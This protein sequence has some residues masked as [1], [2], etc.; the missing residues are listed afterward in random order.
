MENKVIYYMN[1]ILDIKEG[2]DAYPVT[3]EIDP[4]NVCNLNCS[5]CMYAKYL[6][7][8]REVLP[9]EVYRNLITEL[10]I[11]GVKS[12]TMTGGGEPLMN[13][14]FN[15]MVSKAY[16][17]GFKIGLITNGTF[18]HE[19]KNLDQFEFIR[20]SLDAYDENS[21]YKIKG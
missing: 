21:Y 2:K 14:R 17:L 12:I 10:K 8:N 20:I 5:F 6:K 3:C 1:E 11:L 19:V 4:S 18:L 16:S 9:W 7:R 13:P 15:N